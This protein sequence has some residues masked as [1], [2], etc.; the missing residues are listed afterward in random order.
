L[1]EL[2]ESW[3]AEFSRG[4]FT[5]LEE[6]RIDLIGGDLNRGPLSITVQAEGIVPV[7]TALLRSGAKMGDY[8]FVSGELG[9][10][11]VGLQVCLQQ[12]NAPNMLV[13][14]AVTALRR[15]QPQVVLGLALREIANSAI[16]IS[17]G[18]MRD[19]AQICAES[20]L[21]ATIAMNK[22]PL[23]LAILN[24]MEK[25]QLAKL[26]LSGGDDYQ[27]C[28][29]VSATQLDRVAKLAEE[30]STP[31][32]CIGRITGLATADQELITVLD[33]DSTIYRES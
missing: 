25:T 17:D 23:N 31:L 2:D 16:D 21:T 8:I 13:Q 24:V 9:S 3:L 14:N 1:P 27:L 15:P 18:L 22:L 20:G 6:Y 5:I 19:L 33:F 10:A 12:F 30:L 7:G 4:F 32:T 11:A 26:A 28:F 29:T